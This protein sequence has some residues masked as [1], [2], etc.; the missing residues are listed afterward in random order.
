MRSD[1]ALGLEE[2]LLCYGTGTVHVLYYCT[3]VLLLSE[4]PNVLRLCYCTRTALRIGVLVFFKALPNRPKFGYPPHPQFIKQAYP[5][6][7]ET[8]L[9][10]NKPSC[11][12]PPIRREQTEKGRTPESAL[13]QH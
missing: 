2:A 11:P 9:I 8:N 6:S 4:V 10:L 3:T 5:I 13:P 1:V 7:P 12:P